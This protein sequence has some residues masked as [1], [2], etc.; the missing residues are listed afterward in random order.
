MADITFTFHGS[1]AL[2]FAHTSTGQ[3]WVNENVNIEPWQ[4]YDPYVAV[5]PRMA[6]AIIDGAINDGLEVEGE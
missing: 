5:E 1:I 2:M 6:E 4:Y 3:E